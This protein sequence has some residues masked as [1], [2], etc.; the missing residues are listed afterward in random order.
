MNI[1]SA[2]DA[3]LEDTTCPVCGYKGMMPN[4]T[5]YF[6]CPVCGCPGS[7]DDDDEEYWKTED[8]EE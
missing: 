8:D 5:G 3:I 6:D 7:L 1:G 2:Y 4:G